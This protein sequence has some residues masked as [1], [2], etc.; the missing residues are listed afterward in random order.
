MEKLLPVLALLPL[1]S[2]CLADLHTKE[3][4]D[5]D[6]FLIALLGAA[7][8]LVR[9]GFLRALCRTLLPQLLLLLPPVLL[10]W[11]GS[12]D[13]LLLSALSLFF[14]WKQGLLLTLLAFL[15]NGVFCAV[16]LAAHR[17]QQNSEAP[18]GPA[19]FFSYLICLLHF[20]LQVF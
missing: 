18:M 1:F 4:P 6:V 15:L 14:D 11:L 16:L 20:L 2:A 5:R 7:G 12:G 9:G 8:L 19:I 17:L 10:G 13:L 3:I